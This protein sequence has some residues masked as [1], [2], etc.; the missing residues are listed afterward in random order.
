MGWLVKLLDDNWYAVNSSHIQPE[1]VHGGGEESETVV[2]DMRRDI[3][4]DGIEDEWGQTDDDE[5][6]SYVAECLKR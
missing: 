3:S 6:T 2:S 1:I 4:K 5:G